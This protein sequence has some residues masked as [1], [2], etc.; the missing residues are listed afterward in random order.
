VSRLATALVHHP[1]VD[2]QGGVYTTS[3]T[4]L[5]VHD[6]ARSS[7]TYDAD[8]FYVVTPIDA[9]QD[10]ARA[11]AGFWE[12]TKRGKKVPTRAEAMKLVRVVGQLEDAIAAEIEALGEPPLVVVTSA[13]DEDG[14][15]DP[16]TLRARMDAAAGT[17]VVFGTGYGLAP[18]ALAL[19]NARMKPVLGPG[20]YNHLSV[21]SAAAIVLDRL[22]GR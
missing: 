2:A 20:A 5:D 18:A 19:A 13:Q 21:R 10:L 16:A 1:C 15:L 3:I 8:A 7:K 4:N 9:Q 22:R 6:I 17:L 12:N 11:I 14:T